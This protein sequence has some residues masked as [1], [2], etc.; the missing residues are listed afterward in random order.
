MRYTREDACRAWLTNASLP[1]DIVLR[2]MKR[3]GSAE[4]IYDAFLDSDSL[5]F[6][7]YFT[8]RAMN[9]LRETSRRD[10]M[11]EMLVAMRNTGIH[12]M[13]YDD[14]SYP[15]SLL[16][17]PDP[18]PFLFYKGDP[19]CLTGKCISI[20]G[21]R[22]ASIE[23]LEATYAL[24][25]QLA[26]CGIT[27]VSGLAVGID[28]AAHRGCLAAGGRTVGLCACGLDVSYPAEHDNLKKEIIDK[29]GILLS[30]YPPGSPA[31]KWHFQPRN[32]IISGLSSAVVMMECRIRSGSM[33]TVQHALDQGRE[34]FA[35]PGKAGTEYSEGAH[36][37]L[38][39]GANYFET[40]EDIINDLGWDKD[41]SR[42][43]TALHQSVA[44]PPDPN[45]TP[46]QK[47]ILSALANGELSFDQLA[48]A[49]NLGVSQLS[50]ELTMLQLERAISALPGKQYRLSKT[51]ERN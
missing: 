26:Q 31:S 41:L 23:A 3:F 30:E 6:C 38:R 32:R 10:K 16:T 27:V 34:V 11:H 25:Y 24:A 39:E 33:T 20:I 7:E 42:P 49:T 12:L 50:A 5:A 2:L 37:L 15:P 36:Q 40:A 46:A 43:A 28:A 8:P 48:V 44:P 17:I 14:Y 1:T 35:Y 13:S 19:Q 18:P 21:S 29:G 4:A 22:N 51:S 9:A 45:L 47:A